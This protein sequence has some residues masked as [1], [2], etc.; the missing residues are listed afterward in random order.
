MIMKINQKQ[1]KLLLNTMI[2]DSVT[3]NGVYISTEHCEAVS[4]NGRQ[5]TY[6]P[7]TISDFIPGENFYIDYNNVVSLSKEKSLCQ[8][9]L[10]NYQHEVIIK[11][12]NGNTYSS[13]RISRIYPPYREIFPTETFPGTYNI[14]DLSLKEKNYRKE[15]KQLKEQITTL[16]SASGNNNRINRDRV[17]QILINLDQENLTVILDTYFDEY[18]IN[19]PYIASLDQNDFWGRD[20]NYVCPESLKN[21]FSISF[22]KIFEKANGS[23]ICNFFSSVSDPHYTLSNDYSKLVAYGKNGETFIS[24]RYIY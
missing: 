4:T 3:L 9:E 24:M 21:S 23:I 8:I 5:L 15:Q 11:S 1:F 6:I 17:K 12:N 19:L 2:E 14:K 13:K 16:L 18:F 20:L 10:T 7:V 22:S